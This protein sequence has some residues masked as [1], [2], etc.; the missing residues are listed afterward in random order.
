MREIKFRAWLADEK[1]MT[2]DL[3]FEEYEPINDLLSGV[4]HLMQSTGLKD[5]N[6]VEIYEGDILKQQMTQYFDKKGGGREKRQWDFVGAVE[7]GEDVCG[8]WVEGK[9]PR[10]MLNSFGR[11]INDEPSEVIGNIYE[12]KDLL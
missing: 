2:Y 5:K 8:F 1:Q 11:M 3:A 10:G 4:E 9:D 7:W 6:G 12:N